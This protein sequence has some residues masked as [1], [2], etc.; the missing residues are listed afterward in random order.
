M[1]TVSLGIGEMTTGW[2][3]RPSALNVKQK[4]PDFLTPKCLCPN[5]ATRMMD[6]SADI[7]ANSICAQ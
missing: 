2:M 7:N 4:S 1:F 3:C 5:K 6:V